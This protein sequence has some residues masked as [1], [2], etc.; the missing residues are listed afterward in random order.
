MLFP[1]VMRKMEREN[2]HSTRIAFFLLVT[3]AGFFS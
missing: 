3:R 1:P 2:Q